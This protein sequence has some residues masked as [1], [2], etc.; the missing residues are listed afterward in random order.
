MNYLKI[1]L[2]VVFFGKSLT[3]FAQ[4]TKNPYRINVHVENQNVLVRGVANP[5]IISSEYMGDYK[6]ISKSKAI[7][8]RE[9]DYHTIDPKN[10]LEDSLTIEICPLKFP[11]VKKTVAFQ[12]INVPHPSV[13]LGGLALGLNM[14][15]SAMLYQ[16][17]F[18]AVVDNFFY[19]G[20]KCKVESYTFNYIQNSNG[21]PVI[22]SIKVNSASIDD[23]KPILRQ[24][25]SGEQFSFSEIRV[26]TPSENLILSEIIGSFK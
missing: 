2:L 15:K 6:I 3:T 18:I 8:K 23:I 22:K 10:V 20:I 7:I 25:E 19:D 13:K 5:V 11:Q 9:E 14:N 12:I 17:S 4:Q 16:L 1:A 24:I 21:M 26:S